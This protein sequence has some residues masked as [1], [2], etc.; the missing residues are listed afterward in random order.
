MSELGD[1]FGLTLEDEPVVSTI[2]N[3]DYVELGNI[4]GLEYT[5]PPTPQP[6]P[7]IKEQSE[8]TKEI[9]TQ[10]QIS[11]PPLTHGA[12]R[13]FEPDV[14]AEPSPDDRFKI[15][16][17]APVQD[18]TATITDP[19]IE[20]KYKAVAQSESALSAGAKEA[21]IAL[22]YGS[23]PVSKYRQEEHPVAS[24]IGTIAGTIAPMLIGGSGAIKTAMNIPKVAQ[25]ANSG[26][27]GKVAVNGILRA[28]T[29]A[30]DYLAR[31]NEELFSE[32]EAV[33]SEAK[34]NLA[35]NIAASLVS[36]IPET[37]L[38]SNL[39]QPFAQAATD[40]IVESIGQAATGDSAFDEEH[41][42]N[43]IISGVT[44]G[45]FG[46]ADIK[47]SPKSVRG[48]AKKIED[49]GFQIKNDRS[50]KLDAMIKESVYETQKPSKSVVIED[51]SPQF[52]TKTLPNGIDVAVNVRKPP[53]ET[54]LKLAEAN[55]AEY[56]KG[57][58]RTSEPQQ[59]ATGEQRTGAISPNAK[60][61]P[62]STPTGEGAGGKATESEWTFGDTRE[63]IVSALAETRPETF[64][65]L[66]DE[67]VSAEIDRLSQS[68]A[69]PVRKRGFALE[70][71]AIGEKDQV[72]LPDIEDKL[73]KSA[74]K[75][76]D[77]QDEDIKSKFV[78]PFKQKIRN[79]ID[80]TGEAVVDRSYY[81]KRLL[82]EEGDKVIA[83]YNAVKGHSAEAKEQYS[84]AESNISKNLPHD[85][86]K[87][88]PRYLQAKRTI[89]IEGY[90]GEGKVKHTGGMTLEEANAYV[91]QVENRLPKEQSDAIVAT[92]KKYWDEM[93][94]QLKQL[95][96]EGIISK[97]SYDNLIKNGKNYSP[98]EYIQHID[99][100]APDRKSVV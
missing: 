67:N 70:T 48:V 76:F 57:Y 91:N 90:K 66:I 47:S 52:E 42:A 86:E 75:K 71:G 37:F 94:G 6:S 58:E 61:E 11:E 49:V 17:E 56:I 54:D 36:P 35:I 83:K 79:I 10:D 99:P 27:A 2:G 81:A 34:K 26:R 69:L 18:V 60:P 3:D 93:Q 38:P 77:K 85:L 31:H 43:T 8:A 13:S 89:E 74:E 29:A 28:G 12:T 21:G 5:P 23:S 55:D 96:D 40:V 97:E 51:E 92:S 32:D 15:K 78:L 46:I 100:D 24:T 88:F 64:D 1:I 22:T 30:Y 20:E 95:Y 9:V 65:S 7:A 45:L 59:N 98:R 53:T 44:S 19:L 87:I 25:I 72:R 73:A 68:E 39:I 4:F 84:N 14:V 62:T 80:K 63:D 50:E 82:G 16:P 33:S 41:L